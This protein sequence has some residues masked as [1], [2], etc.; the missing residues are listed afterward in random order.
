MRETILDS[1]PQ[2]SCLKKWPSN[3]TCL[4]S[5]CNY[6]QITAL[7]CL[8]KHEDK[9]HAHCT[10]HLLTQLPQGGH[11]A[12]E[13]SSL[14]FTPCTLYLVPAYLLHAQPYI[15]KN[16]LNVPVAFILQLHVAHQ[17][18][19]EMY[20][21]LLL[22]SSAPGDLTNGLQ[23]KGI[24]LSRVSLPFFLNSLHRARLVLL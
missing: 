12:K 18:K 2:N 17:K 21:F 1:L 14:P 13:R 16:C 15:F 3:C 22:A 20:L 6:L 8:L 5:N 10:M 9:N 24:A 7:T 11:K 23:A 19:K 4:Q